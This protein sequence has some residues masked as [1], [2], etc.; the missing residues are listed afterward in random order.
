MAHLVFNW[1]LAS[2]GNYTY[3]VEWRESRGIYDTR[4]IGPISKVDP[5]MRTIDCNDYEITA[6]SGKY[7][8]CEEFV[9]RN[10]QYP[11]N[12]ANFLE[13]SNHLKKIAGK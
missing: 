7:L 11:K 12:N 10:P 6:P 5:V 8:L 2:R 3:V 13:M 9:Y 4:S 1:T